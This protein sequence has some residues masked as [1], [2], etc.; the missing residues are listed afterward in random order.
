M[1]VRLALFEAGRTPDTSEIDKL[2]AKVQELDGHSNS[3]VGI[4]LGIGATS[5]GIVAAVVN[6]F[7]R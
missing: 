7:V 3:A 6:A 4:A 5:G 2:K 1:V